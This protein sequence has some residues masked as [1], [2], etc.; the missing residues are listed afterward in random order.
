MHVQCQCF[1]N[2]IHLSMQL[3]S[4]TQKHIE[5]VSLKNL[6]CYCWNVTLQYKPLWENADETGMPFLR[7]PIWCVRLIC[8]KKATRGKFFSINIIVIKWFLTTI[9][10]LQNV[11]YVYKFAEIF[12]A[13]ILDKSCSSYQPLIQFAL[14]PSC[15][16]P[17]SFL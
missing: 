12:R 11:Q 4:V 1:S 13:I 10:V 15:S 2:C 9:K 3:V 17:F 8:E 16:L 14:L 7:L 6:L 5:I